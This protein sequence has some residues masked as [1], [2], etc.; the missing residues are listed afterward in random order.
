LTGGTP[1][2]VRDSFKAE[3]FARV[4]LTTLA[5]RAQRKSPTHERAGHS[6]QTRAD[7]GSRLSLL[8]RRAK[9]AKNQFTT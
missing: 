9:G 3:L 4:D 1:E 7:G 2:Q 5:S 6:L 8:N